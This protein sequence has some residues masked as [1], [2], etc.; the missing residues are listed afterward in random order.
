MNPVLVLWITMMTAA[1]VPASVTG[2]FAPHTYRAPRGYYHEHPLNYRLM[3]PEK[4]EA[5]KKYPLVVFLHGAGERGGDNAAQLKFLPTQMS[6]PAMRA[7][8]P[9]YILAP[10][11][12]TPRRWA[13]M[14]WEGH[15]M[16]Y[17]AK[18]SEDLEAVYEVVQQ[19]MKDEP[20]DPHRVYITGLSMGGFGTWE[21]AIRHPELFAA[22]APICGGGDTSAVAAMRSVPVWAWHGDNDHAVK[23]QRS[24][25]MVA[26]LKAAGGNVKY[27]EI[28]GGSHFDAWHQAYTRP[29]GVISWLFQQRKK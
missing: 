2:L 29:D 16:A 26:A 14:D 10:Q 23:V 21:L 28:P 8:Y 15:K 6:E 19:V 1:I 3:A 4:D 9:C 22:A 20:I 13:S 11:C 25:D 12:P 17:D 27:T 5:G 18:L 7:K 24:R